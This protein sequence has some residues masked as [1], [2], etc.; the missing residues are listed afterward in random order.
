MDEAKLVMKTAQVEVLHNIALA[1]YFK[2]H[3][4]SGTWSHH[5]YRLPVSSSLINACIDDFRLK[6]AP[7]DVLSWANVL[8]QFSEHLNRT[9]M[10]KW[11]NIAYGFNPPRETVAGLLEEQ[12]VALNPYFTAGGPKGPITKEVRALLLAPR[13]ATTKV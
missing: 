4:S 9:H 6:L 5:H 3:G 13:Q 11:T 12:L 7:G 8:A 1:S 10:E 2:A